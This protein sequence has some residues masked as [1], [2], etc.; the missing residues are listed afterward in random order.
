MYKVHI[1]FTVLFRKGGCV[2]SKVS[3]GFQMSRLTILHVNLGHCFLQANIAPELKE[4]WDNSHCC[5]LMN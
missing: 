3:I 2:L 4:H 1:Y 5:P